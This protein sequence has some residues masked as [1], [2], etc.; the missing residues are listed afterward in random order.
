MYFLIKAK[1]L[2]KKCY[3]NLIAIPAYL[4]SFLHHAYDGIVFYMSLA[5]QSKDTRQMAL[6]IRN[7][8]ADS[9]TIDLSKNSFGDLSKTELAFVFKAIP[10]H[11]TTLNLSRSDLRCVFNLRSIDIDDAELFAAIPRTIKILNLSSIDLAGNYRDPGK[12][13]HI[14]YNL[15]PE[16]EEL[17]LSNNHLRD[18][19]EYE[20]LAHLPKTITK[21]NLT[22]NYFEEKTSEILKVISCNLKVLELNMDDLTPEAMIIMP[23]TLETLKILPNLIGYSLRKLSD[24]LRNIPGFIKYLDLSDHNLGRFEHLE[25][26]GTLSLLPNTLKGLNLSRNGLGNIEG[27]GLTH[28]F[29]YLPK[30]IATVNIEGNNLDLRSKNLTLRQTQV[31]AFYSDRVYVD[32]YTLMKRLT[33]N[34]EFTYGWF[35]NFSKHKI[36]RSIGWY[37]NSQNIGVNELPI[38]MCKTEK[39]D[40]TILLLSNHLKTENQASCADIFI[41][42]LTPYLLPIDVSRLKQALFKIE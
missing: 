40:K 15:P 21:L 19:R 1:S 24:I 18:A 14:F 42:H 37:M 36:A 9:T 17:D 3:T 29:A 38:S 23:S 27:I 39:F 26:S 22:G 12:L 41:K 34:A 25:L 16:L 2:L 7:H 30:N 35:F 6:K 32:I 10:P 28:I 8:P 11:I 33:I 13:K 20:F 31:C 5:W 4:W